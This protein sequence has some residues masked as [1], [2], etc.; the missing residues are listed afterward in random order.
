L[1]DCIDRG[2][3]EVQVEQE[4]IREYVK[5]IKEVAAT[6]EPG[7]GTCADRQEKFEELIDQL[8]RTENPIR[9][10][11]ATVMVGFLAGLFVGEGKFEEIRDNLDLERWFRLPKS[12]ERRIHGHRHAGVR[13]V[14]DGPTLVTAKPT[15]SGRV[16]RRASSDPAC[17]FRTTGLGLDGMTVIHESPLLSFR[18]LPLPIDGVSLGLHKTNAPNGGYLT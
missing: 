3:D 11:M 14:Q 8:Q 5:D 12:H 13:I 10:H 18:E 9:L 7:E 17:I 15:A 2:L 1:A 16:T 6:L 4:K